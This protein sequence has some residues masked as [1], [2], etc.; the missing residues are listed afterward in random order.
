M[1]YTNE[2][3]ALKLAIDA[4]PTHST[5]AHMS[6]AEDYLKW[7]NEKTNGSGLPKGPATPPRPAGYGTTGFPRL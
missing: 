7:L 2:Q 4:H 5:G 3:L 6:R 1:T